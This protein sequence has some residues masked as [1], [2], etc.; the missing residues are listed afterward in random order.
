MNQMPEPDTSIVPRD[1]STDI[2]TLFRVESPGLLRFFA[3]YV[4]CH[5]DAQDLMQD[6]FARLARA[7]IDGDPLS[8]LR[9]I[10]RNLLNS[11][12]RHDK[13]WRRLIVEAAPDDLAQIGAPPQQTLEIEVQDVKRQYQRVIDQLPDKTRKIYLMHRLDGLTYVEI[14]ATMELSVKSVEYHISSALKHLVRG[15]EQE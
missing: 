10:A 15:L 4:R 2:E 6:S 11:R 3:R 13:R 12:S 5:A 1:R 9:R 14:A 7:S 8:Y